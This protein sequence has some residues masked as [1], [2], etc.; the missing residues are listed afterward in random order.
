MKKG[1]IIVIDGTDSSGKNTQTKL[2]VDRV[3]KNYKIEMISFPTYR[4]PTGDIVGDCYLGKNN[5][6][7]TGSW[8]ENPTELDPKIAC[9]YYAANRRAHIKEIKEKLDQGVN[10]IF[11]RYVEAN[12]GHQCAKLKNKKERKELSEWINFLEYEML[13]LPKPNLV[14]F[15]YM[16]FEVAQMLNKERGEKLDAHESNEKYLKNAETCYLELAELYNWEKIDCSLN[17]K[18]P[19]T[20]EEIHEEVFDIIKKS[21]RFTYT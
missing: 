9:L 15:L 7:N 2:L 5:R 18:T 3:N 17:E 20:R 6:I 11:D 8:F 19:R 13:E 16:P 10:L 4:T 21:L 14:I 1:K 12:M